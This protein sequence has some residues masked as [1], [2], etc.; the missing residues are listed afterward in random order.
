MVREK[1]TT[2][3]EEDKGIGWSHSSQSQLIIF[4][5]AE[6]VNQADIVQK[7]AHAEI[8]QLLLQLFSTRL[9]ISLTFTSIILLG[10]YKFIIS[11]NRTRTHIKYGGYIDQ[12]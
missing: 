3:G 7:N 1:W 10:I 8:P 5:Y 11:I 4:G 2:G 9:K 12:S 6:P